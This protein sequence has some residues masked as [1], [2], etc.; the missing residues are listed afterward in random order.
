MGAQ[1]EMPQDALDDLRVA[2]Q[3]WNTNCASRWDVIIYLMYRFHTFYR[4]Q[5][6]DQPNRLLN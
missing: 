3:S 5:T 1:S 6:L 2:D 4:A